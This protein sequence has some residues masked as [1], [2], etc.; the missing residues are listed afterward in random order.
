ME[1]CGKAKE[2]SVCHRLTSQRHSE[3]ACRAGCLELCIISTLVHTQCLV[4][5]RD[6]LVDGRLQR[7]R[8][9]LPSGF[10]AARE[11]LRRGGQRLLVALL[12]A[13]VAD[14]LLARVLEG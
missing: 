1:G 7:G 4:G 8:R 5:L 2:Y 6:C 3:C 10:A 12:G 14:T 11:D 13:T 9:A